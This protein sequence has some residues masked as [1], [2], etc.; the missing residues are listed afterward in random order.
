MKN[1]VLIIVMCLTLAGCAA[2]VGITPVTGS[3]G[4][5]AY[6]LKCSGMGRDR[7]DC[8][9]KAGE[10]CPKGYTVLDD[11][12]QTGGAIITQGSLILVHQQYMTISCK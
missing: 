9:I 6:T 12:N 8:M 2:P 11:S 4:K 7:E 5:Q 3:N 10:I 1:S